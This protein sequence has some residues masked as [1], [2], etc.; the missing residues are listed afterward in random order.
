MRELF[1]LSEKYGFKAPL[2]SISKEF[3][4]KQFMRLCNSLNV[5][6]TSAAV[7]SDIFIAAQGFE[8]I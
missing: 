7:A 6:P 4:F 3:D 1:D 8:N 2:V 5:S